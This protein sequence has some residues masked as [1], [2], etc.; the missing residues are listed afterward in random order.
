MTHDDGMHVRLYYVCVYAVYAPL[1]DCMLRSL[2]LRPREIHQ[3][4]VA[5]QEIDS[6]A[7]F[8]TSL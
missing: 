1:D 4:L 3:L 7:D 8:E 2:C 5:S 6:E